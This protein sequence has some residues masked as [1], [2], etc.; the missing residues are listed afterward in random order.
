MKVFNPLAKSYGDKKSLPTVFPK[1]IGS[2][3][4]PLFKGWEKCNWDLYSPSFPGYWRYGK[5]SNSHMQTSG[6]N[7]IE[8]MVWTVLICPG[9][10]EMSSQ[11]LTFQSCHFVS[12]SSHSSPK[13][14]W[15]TLAWL[16]VRPGWIFVS[17]L[18]TDVEQIISKFVSYFITFVLLCTSTYFWTVMHHLQHVYTLTTCLFWNMHY[19]LQQSRKNVNTYWAY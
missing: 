19:T 12:L 11:L 3:V 9:L 4:D 13:S 6:Y 8:Q 14:L 16:S 5:S 18:N 1:R 7:A 17:D 15:S 2:S 10:D